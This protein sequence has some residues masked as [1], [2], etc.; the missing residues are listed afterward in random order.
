MRSMGFAILSTFLGFCIL[1]FAPMVSGHIFA[2]SLLELTEQ[3]AGQINVRWKQP[4]AQVSGGVLKP[5]LPPECRMLNE[6]SW[7]TEGTG[8]VAAWSADCTNG[9]VGQPIAVEGIARSRADV[10]LRIQLV[11]GRTVV[12]VLTADAS[13]YTVPQGD[14]VLDVM[15]SYGQLGVEHILSGF[16]HLLFVLALILLIRSVRLLIW[17]ITAFTLGHSVTLALAVLGFVQVPQQP[18]EWF[19]ALSIFFL[20]VELVRVENKSPSLLQRRPWMVPGLFGLLHGLGF[21]GALSEIGLPADDIPLALFSFNLGIE[22]GQL[23]FVGGVLIVLYALSVIP[24]RWP[25]AAFSPIRIPAYAIGSLA[26]FWCIE[27]GVAVL[28]A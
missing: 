2:P 8:T 26:A 27:R 6:P 16:D 3:E 4:T 25:V 17:T 9:L 14:T 15:V 20:A 12:Q 7:S 13:T 21:A 10:L 18:V 5:L 11:D 1:A 19:I 28:A 23:A 24:L 22:L